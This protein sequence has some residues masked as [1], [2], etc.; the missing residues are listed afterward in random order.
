MSSSSP[1]ESGTRTPPPASVPVK[2]SPVGKVQP[3]Y[4]QRK[5]DQVQA[6]DENV[7]NLKPLTPEKFLEYLDVSDSLFPSDISASP[8]GL[9]IDGFLP[10]ANQIAQSIKAKREHLLSI[11]LFLTTHDF[12]LDFP[13]DDNLLVFKDTGHQAPNGHVTGTKC[14]PDITAA[15]EKDFLTNG[16]TD[17]ALIRLAGERASKGKTFETQKKNAATYLHYLLLA[18]PDFLIAQG[19]LTTKSDVIFLVGTGGLGI[20]QL[21]V[22]W[23][24]KS[25]HKFIYAFIYRLYDPSHFADSSYTRT[26]FNKETSEATYTVRFKTQ[27]CP[28]FRP[29][30]ARNPFTTR[31]HVLSNPSLTQ[32]SD[33][34]PTV[35]KEQLCRTG[36]R[37]NELSILTKIHQPMNV[38]GVVEAVGGEIIAAPLS[39]G[40][41]KHRLG[42]RQTGLPFTSIPTAKKMLETLFDLLEGI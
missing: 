17:W 10:L 40:R 14:R 7:Q 36:R 28:N 27:E 32:E 35:I 9:S 12:S 29:I 15:F 34:P 11:Y 19:L 16:H 13:N 4:I 22:Q 30:H 5:R 21:V 24:N 18:R 38:P 1:P 23:D 42:L 8:D 20:E 26:G 25:L 39:P 2:S 33:K 3:Y 6:F 37:F 41:E 31:T